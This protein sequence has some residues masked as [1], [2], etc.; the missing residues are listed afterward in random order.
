REPQVVTLVGV[1]GIGKS[2][3]VYELFE[4]IERGD[5]LVYWR[6][7][8]SLPYG[9]GVSFW[10][11]GE[12]VKAQAGVLGSDSGDAVQEELRARGEGVP[13]LVLCTARPELLE[14]RPA[15][16]GGKV[17]ATT[18]LLAPLSDEETARL[19]HGLLGSSVLPA[20]LQ[21]TVLERAGGNPLYAEEF[22]RLLEE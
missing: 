5:E 15:W 7:G 8:R 2:R 14:R 16:G 9:E 20:E 6:R 13:L 22:V 3:L 10:A 21:A 11:L 17:N 4:S 19:V 1:P 12:I 18:V